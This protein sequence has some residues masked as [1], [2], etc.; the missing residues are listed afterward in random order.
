MRCLEVLLALF[1]FSG[2][3]FGGGLYSLQLPEAFQLGIQIGRLR[4]NLDKVS[5]DRQLGFGFRT[6]GDWGLAEQDP[7]EYSQLDN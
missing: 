2:P 6:I 7:T 1:R 3:R 4:C 5:G